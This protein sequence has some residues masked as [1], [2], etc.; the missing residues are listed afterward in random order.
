MRLFPAVSLALLACFTAYPAQA[1]YLELEAA[2][3]GDVDT[4]D[5]SMR[6]HA[7]GASVGGLQGDLHFDHRILRLRNAKAC[8]L[9]SALGVQSPACEVDPPS[10]PC[11]DLRTN[12]VDCG[13]TPQALGCESVSPGTSRLRWI[14]SATSVLN[15]NPIPDGSILFRCTFTV[16]DATRLPASVQQD[17]VVGSDPFGR[18]LTTT[19]NYGAILRD[20]AQNPPPTWTAFRAHT[21]TSTPT[22]TLARNLTPTA[23]FVPSPTRAPVASRTPT[24]SPTRHFT[25]PPPATPLPR[26][27]PC[28]NATYCTSRFCLDLTCCDEA[29]CP[30]DQFC[31]ISAHEGSCSSRKPILQACNQDT[32]CLALNCNLGALDTPRGFAGVCA[33]ARS[34]TPIGSSACFADEHCQPGFFCNERDGFL[35]CDAKQCPVGQTCRD[36]RNPGFCTDLATPTA[37]QVRL[38]DDDGCAIAPGRVAAWPLLGAALLLA[39]VRRR[40]TV[41]SGAGSDHM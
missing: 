32:D 13:L 29:A 23:T 22:A 26:G 5:L 34:P 20:A 12:F 17:G 28:E 31:N 14:I 27:F 36:V 39:G 33:P 8:V 16:I 38:I 24:R 18:R 4:V 11:K 25:F 30:T 7:Q 40:R 6:L 19:A 10:G 3:A 41:P 9:S 21:A 2:V 15:N 35:C 37:T 1:V